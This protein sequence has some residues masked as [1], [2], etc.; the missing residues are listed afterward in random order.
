MPFDEFARTH[1]TGTDEH[2]ELDLEVGAFLVAR[3]EHPDLDVEQQ[4]ARLDALALGLDRDRLRAEVPEEAAR[5]LA[6]HVYELHGFRGNED[7]YGD[8]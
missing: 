4:V 6:E 2:D 8:P 7:A 1:G 3:D 5:L